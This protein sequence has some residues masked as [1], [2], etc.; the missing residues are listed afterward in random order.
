MHLS[1]MQKQWT[2]QDIL[3][4]KNLLLGAFFK[5]PNLNYGFDVIPPSTTNSIPVI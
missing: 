3:I 5:A 2:K 4:D 1:C